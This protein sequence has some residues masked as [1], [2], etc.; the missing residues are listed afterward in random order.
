MNKLMV[1]FQR[2]AGFADGAV[3]ILWRT[4]QKLMLLVIAG[5]QWENVWFG[6][7]F[8]TQMSTKIPLESSDQG[9]SIGVIQM[10]WF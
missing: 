9:L 1:W 5:S 2:R 4:Q 8:Q 3:I 10:Q 7:K 6:V